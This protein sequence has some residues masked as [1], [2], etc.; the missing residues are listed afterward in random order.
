VNVVDEHIAALLLE[1]IRQ[2]GGGHKATFTPQSASGSLKVHMAVNVSEFRTAQVLDA[3]TEMGVASKSYSPLTNGFFELSRDNAV[4]LFGAPGWTK[5]ENQK[6]ARNPSF[7][8]EYPVI[9]AYLKSD[10]SWSGYVMAELQ[11]DPALLEDGGIEF[12]G[13]GGVPASDRVV[14]LSDNQQSELEEAS[15]KLIEEVE[16]SNGIDGDPTFRQVVLG[17]LKAGRELIRAQIFSAE[18]MRLIMMDALKSLI[19][20]YEGHVIGAAAATLMDLLIKRVVGA[21]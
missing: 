20:K 1:W 7:D 12:A 3:L 2:Y 15:S 19:K 11:R 14:T 16:K 21:D 18:M 13:I 5:A 10:P 8:A 4:T 6:P 17:Q 9:D